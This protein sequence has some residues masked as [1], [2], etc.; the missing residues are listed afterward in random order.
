MVE[1]S[2]IAPW[3]WTK[4][5]KMGPIFMKSYGHFLRIIDLGSMRRRYTLLGY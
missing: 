5:E 3:I 2:E 1:I 4:I